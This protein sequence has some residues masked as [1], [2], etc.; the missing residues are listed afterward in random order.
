MHGVGNAYDLDSPQLLEQVEM[1]LS[2]PPA[3]DESHSDHGT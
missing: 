3:S 2:H 1:N